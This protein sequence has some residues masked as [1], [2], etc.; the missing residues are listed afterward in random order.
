MAWKTR[1]MY[2]VLHTGIINSM[3]IEMGATAWGIVIYKNIRKLKCHT[4]VN[5]C[6]LYWKRHKDYIMKKINRKILYKKF[7]ITLLWK[8][9][10]CRAFVQMLSPFRKAYKVSPLQLSSAP[11]LTVHE[12]HTWQSNGYCRVHC[13]LAC[14]ALVRLSCKHC[15]KFWALPFEKEEIWTFLGKCQ[16][17][18]LKSIRAWE[19]MKKN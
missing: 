16:M 12:G 7:G 10:V 3:D 9:D 14:S 5:E 13:R 17:T 2:K 1:W 18:S 8:R 6:Q 19:H 11:D 4:E 15:W